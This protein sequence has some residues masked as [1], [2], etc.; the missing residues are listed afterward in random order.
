[1]HRDDGV[2][3]VLAHVE[4]HAVA[5][6]AGVVH[7]DVDGAELAHRGVDDALRGAEVGDAVVVRHRRAATRPDRGDDLVGDAARRPAAV[8]VPAQVV[9]DDARPLGREQ[10]GDGAADAASRTR[11]D[12]GSSLQVVRP[13]RLLRRRRVGHAG[14]H[15]RRREPI[16]LVER[17]DARS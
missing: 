8:D 15:G 13:S 14:Q 1:M 12:R 3:L 2:P 7:Q 9:D 17:P 6:D 10:L 11:D 5:Q 4:E 16:E